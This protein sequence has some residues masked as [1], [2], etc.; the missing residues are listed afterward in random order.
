MNIVRSY[1][2][3]ILNRYLLKVYRDHKDLMAMQVL[4]PLAKT[5]LPWSRAAMRPSGIVAVLNEIVINRRAH[6]VECGGGIS[7][8]YIAQLLKERGGCLHTVEDD[9]RWAE[10]LERTLYAQGV[11]DQARVVYAPLAASPHSLEGNPWYD[12]EKLRAV[13]SGG[14]IDMLLIDGPTAFTRQTRYARYPAV[15]FFKDQLASDY[16]IILDDINRRGEQEIVEKW[17][18]LLGVKFERR[19]LDGSIAIGRAQD[20]FDV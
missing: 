14:N 11:S 6:I 15:P 20:S 1:L 4:A 18:S 17:E 8:F 19:F 13:T 5:Y 2:G 9:E 7:T 3:I 16:T 12:E 10:T